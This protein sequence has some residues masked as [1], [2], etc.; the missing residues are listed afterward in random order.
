MHLYPSISETLILDS[1][2]LHHTQLRRN[3]QVSFQA[4]VGAEVV[5]GSYF[6]FRNGAI[7]E[8]EY[9]G[10]LQLHVVFEKDRGLIEEYVALITIKTVFQLHMLF[11]MVA[12]KDI[13]DLA[14][15][16]MLVEEAVCLVQAGIAALLLHDQVYLV[17]R[18]VFYQLH[19]RLFKELPPA[20]AGAGTEHDHC[21]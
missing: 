16:P 3:A 7:F 12:S 21:Q 2:S 13:G 15:V 9:A 19:N 1:G 5:R 4:V 18:G 17:V 14:M 20:F 10:V 11:R 6:M 8:V